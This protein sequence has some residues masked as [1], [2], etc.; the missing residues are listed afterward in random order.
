MII[1]L[2]MRPRPTTTGAT[3]IDIWSGRLR[4]L[5]GY[6]ANRIG[7]PGI[8]RPCEIK[9][10]VTGQTISIRTGSLFTVIQVN[11]RDYYFRRASG[12]FDGTG[13]GCN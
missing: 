11:G 2:P 12:R 5:L 8:V 13:L 1:K 4:E 9:D 3:Q 10:A 6:M 7:L